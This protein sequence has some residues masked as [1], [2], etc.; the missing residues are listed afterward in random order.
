MLLKVMTSSTGGN[1]LTEI[2]GG[3]GESSTPA[4]GGS[5]TAPADKATIGTTASFG[6]AFNP[7]S[8]L[9]ALISIVGEEIMDHDE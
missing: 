5:K 1:L 9:S 8:L 2:F 6:F 3:S 7:K 4:T